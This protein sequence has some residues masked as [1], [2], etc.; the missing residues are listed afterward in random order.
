MKKEKLAFLNSM[1]M[2]FADFKHKII[3]QTTMSVHFC[4]IN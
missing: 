1:K 3:F 2:Y 4:A